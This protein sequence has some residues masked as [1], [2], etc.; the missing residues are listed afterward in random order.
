LNVL[1][2]GQYF[3]PDLGGAATRAYNVAKGLSLNGC[4]VTVITAFPH[5]PH[6]RIPKKYALSLFK[7]EKFM[8]SKGFSDVR[9]SISFRFERGIEDG[10]FGKTCSRYHLF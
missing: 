8:F 1:I 9:S 7:V 3:P 2:I 10:G 5:Y 4:K 6:G